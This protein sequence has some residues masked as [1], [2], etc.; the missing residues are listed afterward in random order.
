M[1]IRDWYYLVQ[2]HGAWR[3]GL[4]SPTR[5]ARRFSVLSLLLLVYLLT[6]SISGCR[7]KQQAQTLTLHE[8]RVNVLSMSAS[9][10]ERYVAAEIALEQVTEARIKVISVWVYDTL[11][12]QIVLKVEGGVAPVW[13]GKEALMMC[14]PVVEQGSRRSNLRV[15]RL[16]SLEV[17]AER[18]LP[19]VFFPSTA[20]DQQT[21]M[22]VALMDGSA[23]Q[24]G[25][26]LATYSLESGQLS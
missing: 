22:G 3:K 23:S 18:A 1:P 16:A 11:T 17:A 5:T 15:Y 2:L 4:P 19:V 25:A 20:I 13:L 24:S 7:E 26:A 10:D 21:V 8:Q 6:S 9:P 12:N 14:I